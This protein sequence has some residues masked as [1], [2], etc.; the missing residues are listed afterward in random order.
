VDALRA[1]PVEWER[2]MH[3][4]RPRDAYNVPDSTTML[5]ERLDENIVTYLVP[6]ALGSVLMCAMM[7]PTNFQAAPH[8]GTGCNTTS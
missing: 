3:G 7:Q 6:L 4:G 5:L 1:A 8:C 2:F